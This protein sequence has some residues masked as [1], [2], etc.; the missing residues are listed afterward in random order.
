MKVAVAERKWTRRYHIPLEPPRS[1]HRANMEHTSHSRP[2][3]SLD[4]SH[5]WCKSLE[6]HS[7]VPSQL[8]SGTG[9][10][11][12]NTHGG[13]GRGAASAKE[14][15][16]PPAERASAL[17]CA[18][19]PSTL[20][21]ATKPSTPSCSPLARGTLNPTQPSFANTLGYPGLRV[22]GHLT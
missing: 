3:S 4:L 21:C 9:E 11:P 2:D 18:R 5:F 8:Q 7:V 22:G 19:S 1:R 15:K 6:T 16:N 17:A 13:G 10:G 20:E 12:C 14:V